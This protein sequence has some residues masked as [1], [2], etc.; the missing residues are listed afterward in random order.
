MMATFARFR[1]VPCS[2]LSMLIDRVPGA[3][4][5]SSQPTLLGF[6]GVR[7]APKVNRFRA[8]RQYNTSQVAPLTLYSTARSFT[9]TTRTAAAGQRNVS[10]PATVAL[11]FT[12]AGS[13][14]WYHVTYQVTV[15]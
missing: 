3:K 4:V 5:L 14:M 11:A 10:A 8:A 2:N 9:S 15:P 6:S 7:R 12:L 1:F 13:M